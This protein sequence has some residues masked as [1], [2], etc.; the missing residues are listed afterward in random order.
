MAEESKS[1]HENFKLSKY[2]EQ[3]PGGCRRGLNIFATNVNF[4]VNVVVMENNLHKEGDHYVK[5]VV[6]NQKCCH[7]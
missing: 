5:K 6:R 1:V 2:P 7:E 3:I 4:L